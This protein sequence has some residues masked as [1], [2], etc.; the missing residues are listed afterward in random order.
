[1]Q[2]S[3]VTFKNIIINHTFWNVLGYI[4]FADNVGI[5]WLVKLS[6][7]ATKFGEITQHAAITPLK[8]IQGHP[9]WYQ[10]KAHM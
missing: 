9:F 4:S 2:T 10:S 1:M 3:S 6:P 8:V 7:K 5:N